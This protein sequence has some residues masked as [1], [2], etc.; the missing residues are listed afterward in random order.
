MTF[1]LPLNRSTHPVMA[2]FLF[3]LVLSEEKYFFYN[4]S[5]FPGSS[6]LLLTRGKSQ[7]TETGSG[8]S[9][10]AAPFIVPCTAWKDFIKSR[11]KWFK[12]QQSKTG[13]PSLNAAPFASAS[14]CTPDVQPG[15]KK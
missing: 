9:L 14:D 10:W 4:Q 11:I 15:I 8:F 12:N 6:A 3:F 5:S 7:K 2:G 1:F 13:R